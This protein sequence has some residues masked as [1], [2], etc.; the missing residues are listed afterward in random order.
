MCYWKM[1]FIDLL[2]F[3]G[4]VFRNVKLMLITQ[5]YRLLLKID[6][7]QTE[8]KLTLVKS[9]YTNDFIFEL[10]PSEQLSFQQEG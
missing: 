8:H 1:T 4:C 2:L 10:E 7:K 3:T 6:T 9:Q 5:Y